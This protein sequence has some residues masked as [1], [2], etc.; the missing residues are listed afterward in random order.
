MAYNVED[1]PSTFD[2][3]TAENLAVEFKD[4]SKCDAGRQGQKQTNL[5]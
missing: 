1:S 5:A 4:F 3:Y 2:K